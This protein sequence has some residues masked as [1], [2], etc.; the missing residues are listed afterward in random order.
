MK[1]RQITTRACVQGNQSV[2]LYRVEQSWSAAPA[3]RQKIWRALLLLQSRSITRP[4]LNQSKPMVWHIPCSI[5][6]R[7]SPRAILKLCLVSSSAITSPPLKTAPSKPLRR[8]RH[9]PQWSCIWLC[10]VAVR[11]AVR[12]STACCPQGLFCCRWVRCNSRERHSSQWLAPIKQNNVWVGYC[13]HSVAEHCH[14]AGNVIIIF[15]YAP[16]PPS[17]TSPPPNTYIRTIRER[18]RGGSVQRRPRADG[19]CR[20]PSPSTM[21]GQPACPTHTYNK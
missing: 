18:E 14:K 16:P 15:L 12:S 21:P 13:E 10:R 7:R 3:C 9:V 20:D 1:L 8:R 17:T 2:L 5:V 4:S 19:L 6:R 11:L